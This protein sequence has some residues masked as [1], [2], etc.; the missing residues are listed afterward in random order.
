[1]QPWSDGP[2]TTRS[3]HGRRG[4]RRVGR[5]RVLGAPVDGLVAA[6]GRGRIGWRPRRRCDGSRRRATHGGTPGGRRARSRRYLGGMGGGDGC[7]AARPSWAC[8]GC[9]RRPGDR[10]ARSGGHRPS[11]PGDPGSA[12]GPP[13][14]GPRRLRSDRR[15]GPAGATVRSTAEDGVRSTDTQATVKPLTAKRL[16]HARVAGGSRT[17]ESM[18]LAQPSRTIVVEPVQAVAAAPAPAEPPPG[19]APGRVEM[20]AAPGP[21]ALTATRQ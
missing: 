20:P 6:A 13:V 16:D 18:S 2:P 7:R 15:V 8:V 11:H 3:D 19:E 4:G 5:R 14:G 9:R 10:F 1:V 17:L 21:P 12:A